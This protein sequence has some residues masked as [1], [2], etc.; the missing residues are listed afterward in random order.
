MVKTPRIDSA[1]SAPGFEPL[2]T[3]ST[4]IAQ[5]VLQAQRIQLETL[6]SWQKSMA[7]M[8]QEFLDE[9]NCRFGGGVPID[10]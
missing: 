10:G 5:G 1:P 6:F 8:G 2:F 9:W 4:T 7:A 3:L